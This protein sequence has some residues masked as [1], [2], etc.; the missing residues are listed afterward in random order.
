LIE[1]WRNAVPS[2]VVLPVYCSSVESVVRFP[3]SDPRVIFGDAIPPGT[4]LGSI[5]AAIAGLADTPFN[6]E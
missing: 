3:R 2:A 1:T 5:T 6:A 4:P